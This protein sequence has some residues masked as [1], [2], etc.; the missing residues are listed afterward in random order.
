MQS[1]ELITDLNLL[2][3]KIPW[4]SPIVLSLI[5]LW[6][7]QKNHKLKLQKDNILSKI[8]MKTG[9]FQGKI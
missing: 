1:K 3:K 5:S 7:V 4:A 9:S 2:Y 6:T 8:L